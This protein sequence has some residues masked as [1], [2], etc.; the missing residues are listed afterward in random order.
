MR[1]DGGGAVSR[2]GKAVAIAG[3]AAVL[4]GAVACDGGTETDSEGLHLVNASATSNSNGLASFDVTVDGNDALLATFST[5]DNSVVY[6]DTVTDPSGADV[7]V[8]T[9][10]WDDASHNV[11][12]GIFPDKVVSLNWPGIP[13]E[14][15]LASGVYTV[16]VGLLDPDFYYVSGAAVTFDGALKADS[17]FDDGTL[18]VD[19]VYVGSAI[20]DPDV[21]AAMTDAL[22]YW[23]EIYG[24]IGV[25]IDEQDFTYDGPDVMAAPSL[26]NG[27]DYVAIA[28]STRM[29][30]VNVV[31]VSSIQNGE[32]LYGLAGGIPGPLAS[33]S[34]SG[35]AV[36]IATNAGPDLVFSDGEIRI[37]GETLAH[38]TGHFTGLFHPVESSFD[39]WDG[40]DDTADCAN[41]NACIDALGSNLMFPFPVCDGNSCIPQNELTDQQGAVT[42]RYAA[43][44]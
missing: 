31:V 41:Q 44:E 25:T 36:S 19:I 13:G 33:M 35:V 42:N 10:L 4:A 1:A 6:V 18:P 15:G 43:V 26:G 23:G 17:S 20:D 12:G 29:R 5:S 8:A 40:L 7:M 32:G 9:D 39:T 24:A 21:A 37:L 34:N 14:S 3:V 28:N 16:K 38:E 2:L 27:S 30:G 11:I 22:A